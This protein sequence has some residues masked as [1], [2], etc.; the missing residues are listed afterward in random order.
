MWTTSPHA[1]VDAFKMLRAGHSQPT[2]EEASRVRIDEERAP[3]S[4]GRGGAAPLVQNLVA[5][6]ILTKLPGVTA[7]GAK[8]L[9]N[10]APSLAALAR[11]KKTQLVDILGA[12]S[13]ARLFKFLHDP[14]ALP[15]EK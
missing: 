13:G 12:A 5:Q 14:I 3:T 2:V 6:D 9:M 8:A 1:T 15:P 10:A 11:L 4:G 7:Y